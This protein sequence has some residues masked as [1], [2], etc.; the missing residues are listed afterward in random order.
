MNI[1][2]KLNKNFVASCNKMKEKYGERFERMNGF[3]NE[4]L[5]F[6]DFID[7]FVDSNNVAD[8]SIDANANS[9]T[10]DVRTLLADMM[11]PHTKMLSYNKIFY[12]LTKKYGL[13]TAEEWLEQEWNGSLYLH[14]GSSVSFLPY[15]YA[16]DIEEIVNKGLFFVDKFKTESPKHLTT[17][18]DHVLEFISWTSNRSSGAVGLPSYLIYS[19]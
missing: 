2:F 16:Y 10:K 11:K 18:N 9:S 8:V 12:E 13:Q 1:N 17:F 15:C 14:D 3:H 4:N 5:N 6:T 19:Y 7:N